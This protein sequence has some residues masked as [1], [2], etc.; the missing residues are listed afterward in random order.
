MK[1]PK[2]AEHSASLD[3]QFPDSRLQQAQNL[4]QTDDIRRHK[5]N[6]FNWGI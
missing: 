3:W 1:K 4:L 6:R 5:D 2:K